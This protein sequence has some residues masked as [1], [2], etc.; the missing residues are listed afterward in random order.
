MKITKGETDNFDLYDVYCLVYPYPAEFFGLQIRFRKPVEIKQKGVLEADDQTGK[1][2]RQV[3]TWDGCPVFTNGVEDIFIDNT[4]RL[5]LLVPPIQEAFL[6]SGY[7]PKV[8]VTFEE[9]VRIVNQ[10]PTVTI[11]PPAE[12]EPDVQN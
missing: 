6:R 1:I 12:P 4:T 3:Y 2:A 9:G 11:L 5:L 7:K 8:T 10:I